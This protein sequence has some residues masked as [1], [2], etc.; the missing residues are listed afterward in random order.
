MSKNKIIGYLAILMPVFLL[1]VALPFLVKRVSNTSERLSNESQAAN[2]SGG[3]TMYFMPVSGSVIP[4]SNVPVDVYLNVPSTPSNL[5]FTAVKAIFNISNSSSFSLA[6]ADI[7][8]SFVSPWFY[9][10]VEVVPSG[11][12]LVVTIDAIYNSSGNGDITTGPR[13]FAT[14]NLKSSTS[15][16]TSTI[17][18]DSQSIILAKFNTSDLLSN[19]FTP[20]S[21]SVVAPTPTPLPTATPTPTPTPL[22]TATPTPMPATVNFSVMFQRITT[23]ASPKSVTVTLYQSGVQ[24]YNFTNLVTTS[25]TAGVYS[26]S[27]TGVLAGNYDIYVKGPVHLR[28]KVSATVVSLV[29]GAN[30]NNWTNSILLAGDLNGDNKLDINDVS[31]ELNSW[32]SPNVI[33]TAQTKVY[34][35]DDNG[36][37]NIFDMVMFINNWTT[38]IV[39]GD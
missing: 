29:S 13:K 36:V 6:S 14:L 26:G 28:K 30:T 24:K 11:T 8:P 16:G 22:P 5:G 17:N 34:D 18:I 25:N 39:N 4:N 12:G 35:V 37:I 2:P 1:A 15:L 19:V 7:V 3:S 21:F 32:T 31:T 27:F 33:P 38:P 20:A 10:H 9:A 23:T